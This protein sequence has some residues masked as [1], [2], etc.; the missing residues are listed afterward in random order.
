MLQTLDYKKGDIVGYVEKLPAEEDAFAGARKWHI[1]MTEPSCEFSTVDR[2]IDLG[3][4]PYLP[5]QHVK[6]N[7]GRGRKREIERPMMLGYFF[8]ELPARPEAW[9]KVRGVR[10]FQDF[11]LIDHLR[12]A[13][14]ND[15]AIEAIRWREKNIDAKRQMRLA[16]EGNS[17]FKIGQTV[18]AEVMP[19][20]KQ[21][22]NITGF[23]KRGQAEILLEMA[24][25]G[26]HAWALEPHR[27]QSIE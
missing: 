26:R 23:D 14:L 19:F 25:M 9:R 27:L 1:G 17:E 3:L 18:W 11:L 4:N 21:L 12:P 5:L 16:A 13:I 6:Q 2:L 20:T 15:A 10:G 8:L 7:A 22:A 24:I